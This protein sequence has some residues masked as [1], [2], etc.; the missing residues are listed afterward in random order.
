MRRLSTSSTKLFAQKYKDATHRPPIGRSPIV[1]IDNATFYREY[2]SNTDQNTASNPAI[3]ARLSFAIP[4]EKEKQQHWAIIGASNAGKTT[5]L[6]ILRGKHLCIPPTARSFPYLSSEHVA[7][8]GSRHRSPSQ[9]IQYVG[10]DGE[11]GGVGKTG[12]RGAYLSARYESRREDTDFSVLDY[13]QGNTDLNLSDDQ[14]AKDTDDGSLTTV[15]TD[16]KLETLATMP[17]SNLSNGQIRRARIARALLR[18][19]LVLLLDEPFMGLDPPTTDILDSLLH[20]LA[21]AASPRLVLALRP[22]DHLPDWIT[23]LLHLGPSLQIT[24]QGGRKTVGKKLATSGR[25]E[26]Q[27]SW[28]PT[29][30]SAPQRG[31]P[32]VLPTRRKLT[33]KDLSLSREGLPLQDPQTDRQPGETLVEMRGVCVRYGSKPALGAWNQNIDGEEREGLWWTVERGDRWG[34]FGPNGSGKTTLLSLICSDHPQSYSL[35]IQVFGHGR[36]PRAGRPGI[37]IFDIQARI[38]QSSPEIH[39]FFP[40]NLSLRQTIEN[41]WADTFLG[42]PRLNHKNDVAINACLSWFEAELNPAFVL[43]NNKL[44]RGWESVQ[45]EISEPPDNGWANDIRFGDAPFSAQRVALFLR[46]IVKKPDLLVLDEAFSGM[47]AY[48]RDK[49]L[50]F[51]TWGETKSFAFADTP[52]GLKRVVTDT[53]RRLLSK[54]VFDGLSKDQALL[55]VSHVKEEVPGV[56]REWMGLPE[57]TSGR[58]V[59]F[60]KFEGPLDRDEKAWKEIWKN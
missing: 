4:S 13:L 38:G 23:H 45:T 1:H 22:Q 34:V 60:G 14:T 48:V 59:R 6:E 2:P 39:A 54:K 47:D 51:L 43:S 41:A 58:A 49:C 32:S 37:S 33:A 21:K 27:Y 31:L 35:P 52:K 46:A 18:K 29:P 26:A 8:E 28:I 53:D 56:I 20:G 57:A 25:K 7:S 55:C 15:I 36:L 42:T 12:T 9:A 16:L 44:V 19:P 11:R 50:L 3:F 5:F 30:S 24:H 17:M 10:F 40:R